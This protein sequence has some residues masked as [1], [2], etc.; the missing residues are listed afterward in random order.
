MSRIF[1]LVSGGLIGAGCFLPWMSASLTIAGISASGNVSGTDTTAGK[2]AL[3][4]G[5]AA[6]LL[7]A[8][9]LHAGEDRFRRVA[10]G[11]AVVGALIAVYKSWAMTAQFTDAAANDVAGG[12]V[13]IGIGMW[14]ALTGGA[15]AVASDFVG[16]D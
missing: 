2:A 15:I 1:A 16:S 14:V 7:A 5:F 9:D 11:A 8:L 3:V 4:L 13:S 12:D 10:A 6:L